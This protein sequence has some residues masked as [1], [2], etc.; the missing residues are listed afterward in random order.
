MKF[1]NGYHGTSFADLVVFSLIIRIGTI[2]WFSVTRMTN[3]Y[4]D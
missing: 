3:K 2:G 4:E 1:Q